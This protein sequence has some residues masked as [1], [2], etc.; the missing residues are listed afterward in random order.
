MILGGFLFISVSVGGIFAWIVSKLFQQTTQGLSLLCGGFLVGLLILD[1]IPTAL[2]MYQS[3]GIVHGA[4]IGY[5]LFQ[6]LHQ[7]S[8]PTTVQTPSIYL[9]TIAL[10]LHTIPLSVTIGNALGDSTFGITI[11]ASTILHHLPEGFALTTALLSQGKQLWCLLLVFISLSLCFS[12]FI[13]L[14]HYINLTNH[15]QAILLG[16]SIS[17]LATTSLSEFILQHR[18]ALP[19]D[20]F[21]IYILMGYLLST[22]FHFLL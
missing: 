7:L 1:I 22:L 4:L 18:R 9:L 6:V 17:L 3:F 21:L 10:L 12:L 2:Q 5:L 19:I 13:W 15:A 14:G 11:T 8:H 16:I 20:S